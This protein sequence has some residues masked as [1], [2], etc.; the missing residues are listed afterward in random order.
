MIPRL[1][2]ARVAEYE[3]PYGD[4]PVRHPPMLAN[5]LRNLLDPENDTVTESFWVLHLDGR[6][7]IIGCVRQSDGGW[8]AAVVRPREVFAAALLN[9][10]LAIVVAHNH[11]SGDP[12]PSKEDRQLTDDLCEAGKLLGVKVVDHII[13]GTPGDQYSSFK[14]MGYLS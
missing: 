12:T 9:G 5:W 13:L 6:N 14:E 11:P 3:P 4:E 8:N 10:A 7:Q 2:L 1:R